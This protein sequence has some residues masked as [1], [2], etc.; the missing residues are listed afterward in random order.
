MAK[1]MNKSSFPETPM[2]DYW[3]KPQVQ[4]HLSLWVRQESRRQRKG[5][6]MWPWRPWLE[7]GDYKPS[8]AQGHQKLEETQGQDFF[9][10]LCRIRALQTQ[11]LPHPFSLDLGEDEHPL[12]WAVSFLWQY[13]SY[14]SMDPL[15]RGSLRRYKNRGLLSSYL[16]GICLYSSS[17]VQVCLSCSRGRASTSWDKEC[18]W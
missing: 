11:H 18:L 7:W 3:D 1:T 14:A 6:T 17:R 9:L 5:R 15:K 4:S 16:Q 10:S 8:N 13:G 2:L 12:L